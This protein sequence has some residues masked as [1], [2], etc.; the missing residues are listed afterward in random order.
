MKQKLILK[1]WFLGFKIG[2][3]NLLSIGLNHGCI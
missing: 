3:F 2:P 1:I